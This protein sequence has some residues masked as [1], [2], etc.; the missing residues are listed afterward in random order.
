MFFNEAHR[1]LQGASAASF[2][3]SASRNTFRGV[4]T[5][6]LTGHDFELA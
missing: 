5:L 3:V 6:S 1:E 2:V 4:T